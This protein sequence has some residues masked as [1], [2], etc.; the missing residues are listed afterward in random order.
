MDYTA[1]ANLLRAQHLLVQFLC[2]KSYYNDNNNINSKLYNAQFLLNDYVSNQHKLMFENFKYMTEKK[3]NNEKSVINEEDVNTIEECKDEN[4][5]N[6]TPSNYNINFPPLKE[7]SFK[8]ASLFKKNIF[9]LQIKFVI[10][11]MDCKIINFTDDN[12]LNHKKDK[13]FFQ[14]YI[15]TSKLDL[16][17]TKTYKIVKIFNNEIYYIFDLYDFCQILIH[18]YYKNVHFNSKLNSK[19]KVINK[20]RHFTICYKNDNKE[21]LNLTNIKCKMLMNQFKQFY[22]SFIFNNNN[23]SHIENK[24]KEIKF[25]MNCIKKRK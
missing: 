17:I 8:A 19:I 5:E 21:I 24:K 14:T 15:D 12:Y 13:I 22:L 18:G 20:K 9:Q 25:I 10:I 6:T 3:E 11:M 23:L 4:K 1:E 7:N 16:F 2:Q